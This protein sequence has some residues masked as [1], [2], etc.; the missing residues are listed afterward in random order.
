[1][2]P[3][4][5]EGAITHL[6]ETLTDLTVVSTLIQLNQ[7]WLHNRPRRA[8]AA[9]S[10]TQNGQAAHSIDELAENL[11]QAA[12]RLNLAVDRIHALEQYLSSS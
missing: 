2:T 8:E 5:C 1:M 12:H 11:N 4:P 3:S 9:A 6:H 7:R 10:I